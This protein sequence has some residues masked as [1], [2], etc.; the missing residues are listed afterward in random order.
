MARDCVLVVDDDKEIRESLVEL[1]E[2]YGCPAVGAENGLKAME[3]LLTTDQTCLI[4]LDLSMPVM[5]GNAFREE[6]VKREKLKNI[7]VI[8]ISAFPDLRN[9]SKAMQVD[10]YMQKPLDAAHVIDLARR[11]CGCAQAN[12]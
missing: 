5:D 8:L 6:Q 9:H 4:F 11:Y 2:D 12:A 3:L 1:L 7:P 10:D